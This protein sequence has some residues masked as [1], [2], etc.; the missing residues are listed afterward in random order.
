MRCHFRM[1]LVLSLLVC[2]GGCAGSPEVCQDQGQGTSAVLLSN[3][4]SKTL[5]GHPVAGLCV[6]SVYYC[7]GAGAVAQ[8][9]PPGYQSAPSDPPGCE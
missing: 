4:S 9:A 6:T 8:I 2:T 7:S 5:A 3:P 1:L